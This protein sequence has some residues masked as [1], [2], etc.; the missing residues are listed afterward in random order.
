M[1]DKL[2]ACVFIK[3]TFIGAFCIFESMSMLLPLVD[4][5]IIMDLGSTDG[6]FEKLLEIANANSKVKLYKST[7]GLIDAGVF[8]TLANELIEMCQYDNVLYYQADEIWHEDLIKETRRELEAGHY[9]LSFWRIQYRD[10]FQKVKW[11]PHLVHR[12]GRKGNFNFTGDG[13]NSD[14][15]NDARLVGPYDG[16][17]FMQ[18]GAM[19]QEGIKPYVNMMI[20]DISAVGGFRD[21]IIE[22]RALHAPFWHE[23][24]T[25]E[26]KAADQWAAEARGNPDWTRPESPYNLPSILHYHIG[27]TRYE[28]RPELLEGLKNGTA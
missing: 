19:G 22:K 3:D 26:G 11:F 23:E 5:F 7:W 15:V 8:A 2:S 10:N 20:T 24:P 6:T 12:V 4:E 13:M 21:N 9:D 28:L 1:S 18:W 27:R 14:R 25:I 17:Y 16:G